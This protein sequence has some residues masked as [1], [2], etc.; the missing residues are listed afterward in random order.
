MREIMF[1]IFTIKNPNFGRKSS[2]WGKVPGM[3]MTGAKTLANMKYAPH[4]MA[5]AGIGAGIYGGNKAYQLARS[6]R[7]FSQK[8]NLQ[9]KINDSMA[10][11][12]MPEYFN[13]MA[14]SFFGQR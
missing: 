5:A 13:T 14:R 6:A 1:N 8:G 4:A 12:I 7:T 11:K 10:R 9:Q 3:V 2:A